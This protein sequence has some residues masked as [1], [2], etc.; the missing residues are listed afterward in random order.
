MDPI[1]AYDATKA[2]QL[3]TEFERLASTCDLGIS[4]FVGSPPGLRGI[5]AG[6]RMPG[7]SCTPATGTGKPALVTFAAALASCK[8][9]VAQA[10]LPAMAQADWKCAPRVGGD[11]HCFSDANCMDNLFCDNPTFDAAGSTCKARKAVGAAC[12]AANEC[13]SYTCGSDKKC[14]EKNVGAAYCIAQ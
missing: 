12:A 11:G 14:A 4:A 5:A 8:D 6:T 9:P 1:D 10:C 2:E 3:F 13:E 7:D